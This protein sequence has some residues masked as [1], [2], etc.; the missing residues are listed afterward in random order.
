MRAR[1]YPDCRVVLNR[2]RLGSLKLLF[3]FLQVFHYSRKVSLQITVA[4]FDS[5]AS[6][7]LAKTGLESEWVD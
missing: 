1:G 4:E 3:I 7:E 6:N 2:V 5:V